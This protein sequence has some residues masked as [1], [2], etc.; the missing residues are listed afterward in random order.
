[1]ARFGVAVGGGGN[2]EFMTMSSTDL[3]IVISPDRALP[4]V[5]LETGSE[6]SPHTGRDL[7]T[8]RVA[9]R[10]APH[11]AEA[12]SALLSRGRGPGGEIVDMDGR[13]WGV[14]SYQESYSDQTSPHA[15]SAEIREVERL[16]PERVE[17]GDLTL[18][19][20]R[21]LERIDGA[22]IVIE[23]RAPVG[24][25]EE[26]ALREHFRTGGTRHRYMSVVRVGVEDRPRSMRFGK[27][28]WHRR[29]GQTE[30]SLVLVEEVVDEQDPSPFTAFLGLAEPELTHAL[31]WAATVQAK[32]DA[33][34]VELKAAGVLGAEAEGRLQA[35]GEDAYE[36]R[37]WDSLQVADLDLWD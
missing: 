20:S 12:V 18:Q 33:L 3:S 26:A 2:T 25:T 30:V 14:G 11:D 4:F 9:T 13:R 24:Q 32:F 7:K 36:R 8:A 22:G 16:Q 5:V 1:M 27:T 15:F 35:A 17:V 19:P 28:L 37:R 21:Y 6:V 29:N 23:M 31:D 34:V 10:V